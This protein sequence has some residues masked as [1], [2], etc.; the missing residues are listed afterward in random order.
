MNYN[1]KLNFVFAKTFSHKG[2]PMAFEF[3]KLSVQSFKDD[4][5][6]QGIAS[7]EYDAIV[8]QLIA[9]GYIIKYEEKTMR[10]PRD[11]I[12]PSIK[13][14]EIYNIGGFEIKSQLDELARKE[15]KLRNERIERNEVLLVYAT[16]FAGI[17]AVLLL[18]WNIF[19]FFY[20]CF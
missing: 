11:Y 18:A 14:Y 13:G 20:P 17:A 12:C 16:W 7:H 4:A 5:N 19:E 1:E 2:E 10:E 9:D 8:I 6:K 15:I 3:F